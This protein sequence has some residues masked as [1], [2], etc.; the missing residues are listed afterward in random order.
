MSGVPRED[1]APG[2][3]AEVSMGGGAIAETDPIPGAQILSPGPEKARETPGTLRASGSRDAAGLR[4]DSIQGSRG[5]LRGQSS[6]VGMSLPLLT[7]WKASSGCRVPVL[8]L[9]MVGGARA[10]SS[11]S[12]ELRELGGTC[13]GLPSALSWEKKRAW[14]VE[15]APSPSG[16]AATS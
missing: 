10:A 15:F 6:A 1:V 2:E 8:W 3:T 13:P 16:V 12:E 4:Q 5:A 9:P 7:Q 11:S 14:F